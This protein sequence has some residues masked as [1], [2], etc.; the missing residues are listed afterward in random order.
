MQ[1]F[2]LDVTILLKV[3]IHIKKENNSMWYQNINSM[4]LNYNSRDRF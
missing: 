1:A 3:K 2:L 4:S